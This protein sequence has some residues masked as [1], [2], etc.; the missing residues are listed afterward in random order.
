MRR[1]ATPR[2]AA[3]ARATARRAMADIRDAFARARRA[4]AASTGRD[5]RATR[6]DDGRSARGEDAS[7]DGDATR[8]ARR[9]RATSH[10][11]IRRAEE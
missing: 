4:S 6:D 8:D 11:P 1:R 3:H 9:A 5:A 2:V 10:L 7:K